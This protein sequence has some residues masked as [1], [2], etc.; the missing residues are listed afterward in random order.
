[1]QNIRCV[2]MGTDPLPEKARSDNFKLKK[3]LRAEND[4]EIQA[5]LNKLKKV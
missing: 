3:A 5:D 2:T 4:E 1:M